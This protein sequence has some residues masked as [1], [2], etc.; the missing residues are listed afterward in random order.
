MDLKKEL[1]VLSELI[2]DVYHLM[3]RQKLDDAL[4]EIEQIKIK[5]DECHVNK[6]YAFKYNS[7]IYEN[8]YAI[9][10]LHYTQKGAENAMKNHKQKELKKFNKKYG[11]NNEYGF[12]FGDTEDWC[13]EPIPVFV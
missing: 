8:S 12:V 6:L 1:D 5:F 7:C 13:V 11:K 3:D 10:S 2:Q 9:I 4:N